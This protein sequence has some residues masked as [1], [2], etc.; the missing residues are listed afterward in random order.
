MKVCN[1]CQIKKPVADFSKDKGKKD[2]YCTVCKACKVEYRK[3]YYADNRKHACA[4]A[5]EWYKKNKNRHKKNLKNW[6]KEN[7]EWH[8]AQRSKYYKNTYHNEI[9]VRI[10]YCA[11][12]FVQRTLRATGKDKDFITFQKIGYTAQDLKNRIEMNFQ[13]GMSWKNHGEWEIDHRVPLARMI[14]RG[15][16][17]VEILNCLANLKPVW[18]EQNRSKGAR[19]SS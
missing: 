14:K 3:K 7:R 5:S 8:L 18:K 15:E 17:R 19:F 2:G 1:K 13:P 9:D 12:S 4:Y 6:K 11:R 16:N 10:I